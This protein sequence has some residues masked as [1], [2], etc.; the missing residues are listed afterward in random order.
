MNKKTVSFPVK[1]LHPI[2]RMI[3]GGAQENTLYTARLLDPLRFK[4]EI[5]SGGQTGSE[6]SL[7]PEVEQLGIPLIILP[8]LVR[9]INPWLDYR[10]LNKL[11]SRMRSGNYQIVHTH[12]SK[13]GILG[14]LAAKRAG[15]PII[16]HTV[17]GW[18][19]HERMRPFVKWCYIGIERWA[20]A[21]CDA[22]IVVSQHDK[23]AGLTNRIGH[24]QQYHLIRS[25]IPFEEFNLSLYD[26]RQTR[27]QLGLPLEAV[28]IGSVGRFSPQKN[29]LDWVRIASLVADEYPGAYFL[30]V[31]DGPLRAQVEALLYQEGLASRVI[32]TGIRR[33]VPTLLSAMDIFLSTSLWEGMPRTVVQAMSMNLPVVAYSIDGLQEI[34]RHDV[35]GY[36]C[37]G[38]DLAQMAVAC[39]Y[40]I[41][42]EDRRKMMGER[43]AEL[44]AKE[45]DLP[46][47]IR[48]IE[49]LYLELIEEKKLMPHP[50][51]STRASAAG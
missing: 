30:M 16:L 5:L 26:G 46:E 29:P 8:E 49:A 27:R 20:A 15:I 1:V 18:S 19:F 34:I 43:G 9:Q 14:R 22:I 7:I 32:L 4:V 17:H 38:H 41:E 3:V 25:A 11:T 28:V 10:A 48:N 35:S 45:F 13:A 39:G 24:A 6:G 36:L 44:A 51:S 37:P 2:T 50:T 33:D 42:N 12:S 23:E 47:M 31:G 40:L 21:S